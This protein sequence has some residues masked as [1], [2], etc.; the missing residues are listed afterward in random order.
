MIPVRIAAPI[1]NRWASQDGTWYHWPHLSSQKR[2][3]FEFVPDHL[4][5]LA[6]GS[7]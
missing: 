2:R 4:A 6:H 3:G 5:A 7:R 1:G